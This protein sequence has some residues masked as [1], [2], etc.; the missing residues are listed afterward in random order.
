MGEEKNKS[1]TGAPLSH[2]CTEKVVSHTCNIQAYPS[3]ISR[4][5]QNSHLP[6]LR[7]GVII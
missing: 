5:A 3:N 1:L 4:Q 7:G 6:T 2:E